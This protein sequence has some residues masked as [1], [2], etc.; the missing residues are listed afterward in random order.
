MDSL[1]RHCV[2]K[3]WGDIN[4]D[5]HARLGERE[6][7]VLRPAERE[8]RVL[9]AERDL[10]ALCERDLWAFLCEREREPGI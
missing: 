6:R 7:R 3:G 8:R 10:R 2:E 9:P 5:V 4:Q 1:V